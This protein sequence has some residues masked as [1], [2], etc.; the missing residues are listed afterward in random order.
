MNYEETLKELEAILTDMESSDINL[1]EMMT[2]YKR[3]LT[4]Y[5][6]LEKY[7]NEYK[8]EIKLITD[9][10]MEDFETNENDEIN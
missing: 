1:D 2:K 8:R 5:K 4:L 7:L 3:A 9:E 10:G 6:E